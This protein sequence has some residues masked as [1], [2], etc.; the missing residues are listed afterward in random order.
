MELPANPGQ[1][2]I[3]THGRVYDL[4]QKRML[5]FISMPST[6]HP[7]YRVRRQIPNRNYTGQEFYAAV[8]VLLAFR[9]ISVRTIHEV[10]FV[11]G[12]PAN[13]ELA[14]LTWSG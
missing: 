13:V 1:Y 12:D 8:Q 10:G 7:M 5:D 2:V 11:D 6:V 3:S 4:I 9:G 14:N